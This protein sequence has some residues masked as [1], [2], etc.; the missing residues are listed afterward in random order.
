MKY[1][2]N[3]NCFTWLEDIEAAQRLMDEQLKFQW[4]PELDLIA[5]KL[6]PAHDEIYSGWFG[7]RSPAFLLPIS[8]VF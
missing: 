7:E 2:Q 6:N 1:K 5:F 4:I 3:G 8:C